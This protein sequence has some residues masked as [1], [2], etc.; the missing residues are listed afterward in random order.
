MDAS[1]R[2]LLVED[3]EDDVVLIRRA[4]RKG[5]I[6]APLQ[7]VRDGDDAIDYFSGAGK[8]R[9]EALHPLP[10]IV[11][12]DLRLPRRSGLEVLEWIKRHPSLAL[13]PVIVFTNSAQD[14]DVR[15]AYALGANSY[16]KKPY[17]LQATTDLLQAVGSYWLDHNER[18]PALQRQP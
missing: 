8:Y 10:A 16:L 13:L 11:L 4:L 12:L 18:P 7:V 9:D 14:T 17:T 3:D 5:G 2:I 15:Q 6:E 1:R